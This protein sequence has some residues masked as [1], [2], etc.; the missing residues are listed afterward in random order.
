MAR[1]Q[2]I[3]VGR[4]DILLFDPR[5][6]T[7]REGWNN[8]HRTPDLE[9]HIAVL[10]ESIREVGLKSPLTVYKGEEGPVLVDGHC[11]MDAIEL[12]LSQGV[13]I[14]SV[15]AIVAD[16]RYATEADLVVDQII[17]NE[18]RPLTSLEQGEIFKRL[19]GYN[20]KI[21]DIAKKVGM[22]PANVDRLLKLTV[23]PAE[24]KEMIENG[25]VA[26][27]VAGEVI[28]RHG[29][30]NA[31]GILAEA[32]EKANK[33]GKKK[34]TPR[35]LPPAPGPVWIKVGPQLQDAS[36]A[37]LDAYARDLD[38]PENQRALLD[39]LEG[40]REFYRDTFGA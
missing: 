20:W 35:Y 9:E 33:D 37:V 27:A 23:A 26:P 4:K 10:A 12:L 39:A 14:K 21:E 16:I 18:G 7:R 32:K 24:V 5:S 11:R 28:Q 31:A 13:E 25:E 8:R 6:I 34:V 22:T 38:I 2:D 30:Q 36:K 29:A 1:L 19:L 15:P 3:A 17:R 40:F